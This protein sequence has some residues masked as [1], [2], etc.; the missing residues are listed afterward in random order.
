MCRL[1][2]ILFVVSNLSLYSSNDDLYYSIYN[3]LNKFGRVYE[4]I[5]NDY[6]GEVVPDSLIKKSI[7]GM[8]SS[9]D[10]YTRYE[11]V[12][13]S[14]R[15]NYLSTGYYI[16]YGFYLDKMK[17]GNTIIKLIENSPAKKSGMRIGDR[18][19]TI[20]SK[21]VQY[22]N[23][24][25]L[26]NILDK[27]KGSKSN[28]VFI[29]PGVKDTFNVSI[30]N[31]EIPVNDVPFYRT[32]DD[33]TAYIKLDQFSFKADFAFRKALRD[34]EYQTSFNNLIID[35]RDNPGGVMQTALRILELFVKEN[36]LL[37][38]TRG[39]TN[40]KVEEYYSRSKPL[41]PDIKIAV[42]IN[43]GSASASEIIAGA[44]QDTDRG[45]VIG[46][47]SF[48]KGLVQHSINLDEE[49]KI[50]LTVAKYYTPSGRSIQKLDYNIS[51]NSYDKDIERV[52]DFKTINGRDVNTHD[53]V[54]PDVAVKVSDDNEIIN[55][56]IK[57][58]Y[59]FNFAIEYVSSYDNYSKENLFKVENF[60]KFLSY[61]NSE[62]RLYEL[63]PLPLISKLEINKYKELQSDITK[64]N[65]LLLEYSLKNDLINS[66]KENKEKIVDLINDVVVYVLK[67]REY[68]FFKDL[69]NDEYILKATETLGTN[70]N[71]ILNYAD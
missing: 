30:E 54:S 32:L 8:L 67:G 50:N 45:V 7:I 59:I 19:L 66:I 27:D 58:D 6:V 25:K 39:K 17:E 11:E 35:L 26:S 5:N 4:K 53:G 29:R 49:S 55:N 36:T 14:N 41:Y 62:K 15:S 24:E 71:I 56:L 34:I 21:N 10:P 60:E 16:G 52:G 28:F 3:N 40:N 38:T 47:K 43:E 46:R 63:E 9:L 12:T 70:Y 65:I 18:L 68:S 31:T 37:L 61:L 2:L 69:K 44:L 51:D 1:I 57:S 48:G 20:D 22:L 23:Q 13:K 33:S 42:L 64:E